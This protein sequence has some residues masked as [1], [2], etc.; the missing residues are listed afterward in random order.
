MVN[1]RF[2]KFPKGDPARSEIQK[3]KRDIN[4]LFTARLDPSAVR[5]GRALYDSSGTRSAPAARPT[6]PDRDAQLRIDS[7]TDQ[8]VSRIAGAFEADSKMDAR[9]LLTHLYREIGISAVAAALSVSIGHEH[10]SEAA[11]ELSSPIAPAKNDMA[12]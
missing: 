9:D 11:L 4:F 3:F 5:S 7:M 10:E 8:A 12:A 6:R 2:P 1:I